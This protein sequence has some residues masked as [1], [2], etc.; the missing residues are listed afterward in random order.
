MGLERAGQAEAWNGDI[1]PVRLSD[2]AATKL[3]LKKFPINGFDGTTDR[4]QLELWPVAGCKLPPMK[5]RSHFCP[6]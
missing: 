4:G 1:L 5:L 2:V 6:F 3:P